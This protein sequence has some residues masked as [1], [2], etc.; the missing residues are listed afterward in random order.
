[1]YIYRP[2]KCKY[3]HLILLQKDFDNH[4][5]KLCK[6]QVQCPKC[7]ESFERGFYNT[8]HFS[9]NDENVICLKARINKMGLRFN[10]Y[11]EKMEKKI[12]DLSKS[13]EKTNL[14]KKEL[15]KSITNLKG[16][17]KDYLEMSFNNLITKFDKEDDN[18]KNVR[19]IKGRNYEEGEKIG[20]YNTA[21]NSPSK[22]SKFNE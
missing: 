20:R 2:V 12:K 1:M 16:N 4:L 22:M 14:E 8:K 19:K 7:Q 13:L 15:I 18:K 11:R 9:Q 17:F 5:E 3:C 6:A 10:C 21:R